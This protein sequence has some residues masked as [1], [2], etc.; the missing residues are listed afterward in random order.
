VAL[1]ANQIAAKV[2]TLRSHYA[3]RDKRM[4]D[5]KSVRDG[6][7]QSVFPDLWPKAWPKPIIANF[8]DTVA[9][10]LTEVI[11]PLPGFN[12]ASA[13][14]KSAEARKFADKRT[15]IAHYYIMVNELERQMLK[16][17]DQYLT[18]GFV[19]FFIEPDFKG[20][21]PRIRTES[22]LYAYP[23]FDRFDRL[24][25]YT[26]VFRKTARE[27]WLRYP[28]LK[29]AIR[30]PGAN[31]NQ[32]RAD[33]AILELIRY[34]D[35]DQTVLMLPARNNLV[36]EVIPNPVGELMIEVA[37]RPNGSDDD[38]SGQFDDVIWVQ[39][40]RAYMALLGLEATEKSVQA[41]LA[42]PSDVQEFSFGAD[43]IIRTQTPQGVRRVGLEL[44]PGAFQEQAMLDD[45]Q[46]VGA[47]YP[48]ARTGNVQ[49]SV[50][51]G[52]GVQALMGG[53][54][55]QIKTA[56]E[57]FAIVLRKVISKCFQTD[58]HYW[59]NTSRTI[60]GEHDNAPFEITYKPS[61]DIAGDYTI[62]V[63]YGFMS[64]LQPNQ[65]LVFMLQLRGDKLIS[66]DLLQ[67][68]MPFGVNLTE[69]QAKIDAEEVRD[70]LKQALF[71]VGQ[72]MPE[73]VAQGMDPTG[74]IQSYAT[75]IALI[76]KGESIE[77]AALKAFAPPPPPPQE[78]AQPGEPGAPGGDQGPP[79]GLSPTGAQGVA[80]GQQGEGRGGR[81]ALQALLAGLTSGGQPSL[82]ANVT[83]RVPVQI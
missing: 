30:G 31:F 19:P 80:P 33:N 39:L 23:E 2:D 48:D 9:R 74:T 13:T 24:Q 82:Q 57:I 66:R 42:V 38:M 62:N 14:M 79:E 22:P 73:M 47:R 1:D 32:D 61:K 83:Q 40:A 70:A 27:I 51:T 11:A 54:D 81:P 46:R 43:S 37:V 77:D 52:Q 41:P 65:A 21:L 10:D 20:K 6:D 56:Q 64:G 72:A 17:V 69:E 26:K 35:K 36:L 68:Q 45:E 4:I 25:S 60:R 3:A 28:E 15:Q 29:T 75:L 7:M 71:G 49:S 58:E 12:C 63:S 44:P 78:E 53:F 34:D 55:T 59:P 5:V 8:V 18:Y 76:T 16:A 50:I 67:R